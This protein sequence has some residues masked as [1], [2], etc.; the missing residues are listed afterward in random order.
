MTTNT[1]PEDRL[2]AA[3]LALP[4]REGPAYDYLPVRRDGNTVYLAGTLGKENGAVQN[5]GKVG[6]EIAEAEAA[7]QMKICALQALNWLRRRL[8]AI[9]AASRAYYSSNA[10]SPARR[11]STAYRG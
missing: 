8:A 7:R 1:T 9:S 10:T 4:P 11:N 2:R 5:L 3:G 6:A